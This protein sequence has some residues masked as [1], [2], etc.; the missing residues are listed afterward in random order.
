MVCVYSYHACFKR[1]STHEPNL[2][3]CSRRAA[4][5]S[6]NIQQTYFGT[7]AASLQ[8]FSLTT[9]DKT[10]YKLIPLQLYFVVAPESYPIHI[11]NYSVGDLC[12]QSILQNLI[13]NLFQCKTK[14][15]ALFVQLQLSFAM[16]FK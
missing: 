6:I 3:E 4:Y 2:I 5:E 16:N 13:Y 9:L 1:C 12:Q 8:T 10:A 14:Y 7:A 15:Q 11:L